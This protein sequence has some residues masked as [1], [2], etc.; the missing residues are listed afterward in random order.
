MANCLLDGVV[1]AR[2]L[3]LATCY[4]MI[5]DKDF[6]LGFIDPEAERLT[7]RY[8]KIMEPL[9]SQS[10]SNN[11]GRNWNG[12]S[13]WNDDKD[14]WQ[15]RQIR[16]LDMFR[17]AL[18]TKAES[19]LNLKD[20]EMVTFAPGTPYDHHSMTVETSN[21]MVG[22]ER[23]DGCVVEF[24]IQPAVYV[25]NK[26]RS[27]DGASI[28]GLP[29]ASKNFLRNSGRQKHGLRPSIKAVV[30]IREGNSG[31]QDLHSKNANLC[32]LRV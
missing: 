22:D 18:K 14:T 1:A 29:S 12:F 3:D 7:I 8:S 4:A 21:G 31:S 2:N 25:Y 27:V 10:P 20:Y 28:S 5:I 15:D 26:A 6:S 30:I 32:S 19:T 16:L 24:C 11:I 17:V 9:F 23:N 13:T